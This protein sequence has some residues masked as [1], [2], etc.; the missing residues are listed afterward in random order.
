MD[1]AKSTQDLA[2]LADF[3][4][5]LRFE[6]IPARAVTLIKQ[7]F[8]DALGCAFAADGL[9]PECARVAD[10]MRGGEGPSTLLSSGEIGRAHV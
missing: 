6:Q 9:E 2:R 7:V 1:A 3:A 5:R 8:L 4:A 10:A